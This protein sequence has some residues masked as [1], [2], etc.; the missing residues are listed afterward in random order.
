[1]HAVWNFH[2][3]SQSLYGCVRCLIWVWILKLRGPI[4]KS[5]CSRM[6]IFMG[7]VLICF[8]VFSVRIPWCCWKASGLYPALWVQKQFVLFWQKIDS[9]SYWILK[10][11]ILSV[12][13]PFLL[14]LELYSPHEFYELLYSV[15]GSSYGAFPDFSSKCYQLL[16]VP[17]CCLY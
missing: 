3:L 10:T 12:F 5:T 7:T 9:L 1:M 16:L 4:H 13:L 15:I 14:I 8:L 2:V 11:I 17:Q 6:R